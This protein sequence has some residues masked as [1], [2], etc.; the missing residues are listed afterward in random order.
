[1]M[2]PLCEV[3]MTFLDKIDEETMPSLHAEMMK[4]RSPLDDRLL[5]VLRLPL[6]QHDRQKGAAALASS[7]NTEDA[8][9]SHASPTRTPSAPDWRANEDM[10]TEQWREHAKMMRSV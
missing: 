5:T 6:R 7:P 1:M 3:A 9:S 4:V 2:Y 8:P 10:L